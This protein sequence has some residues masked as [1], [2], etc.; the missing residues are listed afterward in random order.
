MDRSEDLATR[1]AACVERFREQGAKDEQKAAFR[2][3]LEL[4]SDEELY[5]RE[6]ERGV[7]V[8]G[9]A[10]NTPA[11]GALSHRLALHNVSEIRILPG[12]PPAE[13]FALMQALAE[14]PEPAGDDIGNR[15]AGLRATHVKVTVGPPSPE[16]GRAEGPSSLG[17]EGLLRGEPMKD[18]RSSAGDVAGMSG[19]TY[20][21][22][23][24]P[25]DQALPS[26]GSAPAADVVLN[27][28]AEPARAARTP[29]VPEA[30]QPPAGAPAS[31][32]ENEPPPEPPRPP[33]ITLAPHPLDHPRSAGHAARAELLA[34]LEAQP[35]GPDIGDALA[36][37]GQLVVDAVRAQEFETALGVL[38]KVVDLEQRVPEGPRRQYGIALRRMYSK[39]LLQGLA[40]LVSVPAHQAAAIAVLQR[41][42]ADGVEV[43]LERLATEQ[44]MA[45]RRALF[46]ALRH[47]REGRSQLIHM[48]GDPKWFVV[49]NAAELIGELAVEEAVPALAQLLNHRDDRVRK[50]AALALAKIGTKAAGE[51]LRR[52]LR[53]PSP[54]IRLQVAMGV[55]GQRA[56]G[57][58]M[59]LVVALDEEKDEAVQ[60]ELVL[61]LGRI[62]TGDAV[63]ALVKVAQPAGRVFG[64][65]PVGLR[66]AAVDAL[67]LAAT[68][69]AL[70]AL[71]G[72]SADADRQVGTAAQAAVVEV[73]RRAK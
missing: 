70:G 59:P 5:L 49:R 67:R 13:V 60:R 37:L 1:F 2:S 29:D 18:I 63:Q 24:P 11:L 43:L 64:R 45:E 6:D 52:A 19:F 4:L 56:Q 61:A 28:P 65:K 35:A 55:G 69:A 39:A 22:E 32:R 58:A 20:D 51:P 23:P 9:G 62:G 48:L 27:V 38:N 46:D 14:P 15:L 73:K 34:A 25:P 3:L 17:T 36:A 57:L 50:A 12:A 40:G 16:T 66:L 21:P 72:L 7:R 53:D 47:M 30:A 10:V 54:E 68:P 44:A 71:E 26:T 41:S 31:P 33:R 42:G 8:N